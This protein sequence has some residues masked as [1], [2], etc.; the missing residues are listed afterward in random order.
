MFSGF[1][2]W[3]TFVSDED[4]LKNWQE[5][6]KFDYADKGNAWTLKKGEDEEEYVNYFGD[7]WK[8]EKVTEKEQKE[9]KFAGQT[10]RNLPKL[11]LSADMYEKR[12]KNLL[13]KAFKVFQ[14]QKLGL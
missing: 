4:K 14:F 12:R 8:D 7:K 2:Q 11:R 13:K 6:Y 9:V 10:L 3:I 1:T 5:C